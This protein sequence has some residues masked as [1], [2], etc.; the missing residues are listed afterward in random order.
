[1]SSKD[2]RSPANGLAAR[3]SPSLPRHGVVTSSLPES[4]WARPT[5]SNLDGPT[6]DKPEQK[7]VGTDP[8]LLK[9]PNSMS[10][11]ENVENSDTFIATSKTD[12]NP[13]PTTAPTDPVTPTPG[14]NTAIESA[15]SFTKCRLCDKK[16]FGSASLCFTCKGTKPPIPNTVVKSSPFVPKT[17]E[18]DTVITPDPE[19]QP[20]PES[21]A[22]KSPDKPASQLFNPLKRTLSVLGSGSDGNLFIKKKVRIFKSSEPRRTNGETSPQ[23]RT[24]S[25]GKENPVTITRSNTVPG[26]IVTKTPV[27]LG[28]LIELER[29]RK[30]VALL[31]KSNIEEKE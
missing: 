17:P 23:Q 15:S 22:P 2:M 16:V 6:S 13:T 11:Q 20:I 31:E 24:S 8:R 27:P 4:S 7:V 26:A 30:Q 28:E 29:L 18:L 12:I 25:S 10:V 5:I 14:L 9:R 19:E 21:M 1:M 3:R